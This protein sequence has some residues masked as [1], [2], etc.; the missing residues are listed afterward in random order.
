[1]TSWCIICSQSHAIAPTRFCASC[2]KLELESIER[3]GGES[4]YE[5]TV[6]EPAPGTP[7]VWAIAWMMMYPSPEAV[8]S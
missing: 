1:M 8:R 2:L 7:N 4:E 3:E 6:V 5:Y